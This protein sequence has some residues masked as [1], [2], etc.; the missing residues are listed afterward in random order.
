MLIIETLEVTNM[1]RNKTHCINVYA[2][3]LIILCLRI[4]KFIYFN[5]LIIKEVLTA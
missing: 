5:H 2:G 1:L 4:I 3:I